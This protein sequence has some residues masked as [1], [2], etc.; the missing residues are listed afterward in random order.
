MFKRFINWLFRGNPRLESIR[1]G[2]IT[3]SDI[4]N[5]KDIVME[6][7]S[8]KIGDRVVLRYDKEL[9]AVIVDGDIGT[10]VNCSTTRLIVNG[11]IEGS[12]KV[13]NSSVS[14]NG[15]VGSFIRTSR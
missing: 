7:N 8:I 5:I 11:N 15:N 13:S 10:D 2:N 1:D 14:V 4:D 9:D 6:K 12:L 3:V